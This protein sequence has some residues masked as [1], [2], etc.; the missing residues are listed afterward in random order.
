MRS[1]PVRIAC[2]KAKRKISSKKQNSGLPERGRDQQKR[3]RRIPRNHFKQCE[4]FQWR[5]QHQ[6]PSASDGYGFIK[7]QELFIAIQDPHS[8]SCRA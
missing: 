6:E 8:G 4:E 2:R 5:E 7:F 1:A 3:N